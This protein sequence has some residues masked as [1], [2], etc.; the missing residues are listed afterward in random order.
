MPPNLSAHYLY[1]WELTA[2]RQAVETAWI[3]ASVRRTFIELLVHRDDAGVCLLASVSAEPFLVACLAVAVIGHVLGAR[4]AHV[5]LDVL[6]EYCE[7]AGGE[8]RHHVFADELVRISQPL[9]V[10]VAGR[11]EHNARVLRSPSSQ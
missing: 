8:V 1:L 2:V 5:V 6:V 4:R 7:R 11:V 10:L 9:R 3:S